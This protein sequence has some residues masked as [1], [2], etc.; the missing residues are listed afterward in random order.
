MANTLFVLFL[1]LPSRY[2]GINDEIEVGNNY[3][4]LIIFQLD[5]AQHDPSCI[6]SDSTLTIVAS[7]L[8]ICREEPFHGGVSITKDFVCIIFSSWETNSG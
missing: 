1:I 8:F 4:H 7:L 3:N 5:V 6:P 2:A